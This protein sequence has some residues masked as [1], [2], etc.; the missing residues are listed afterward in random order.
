MRRGCLPLPHG[1]GKGEARKEVAHCPGISLS[2]V[3]NCPTNGGRLNE[4]GI[5]VDENAK[6]QEFIAMRAR[7]LPLSKVM[8]QLNLSLRTATDWDRRL[9]DAIGEARGHVLTSEGATILASGAG[10]G[11]GPGRGAW[12][13]LLRVL[14]ILYFMILSPVIGTGLLGLLAH[15]RGLVYWLLI[16]LVLIP[17]GAAGIAVVRWSHGAGHTTPSK[18]GAWRLRGLHFIVLA[19]AGVLANSF[20]QHKPD[21]WVTCWMVGLVTV[22]ITCLIVLIRT[23]T[24]LW[25][26]Y[27]TIGVCLAVVWCA[28]YVPSI[29]RSI[30][31]RPDTERAEAFAEV[32]AN[33][34]REGLGEIRE[35]FGREQSRPVELAEPSGKVLVLFAVEG[36]RDTYRLCLSECERFL[37]AAFLAPSPADLGIIVIHKQPREMSGS[38]FG[39]PS[40]G[41]TRDLAVPV[42]VY[43]WPDKASVRRS[44]L[45]LICNDYDYWREVAVARSLAR[46][47]EGLLSPERQQSQPAKAPG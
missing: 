18:R 27:L 9:S 37:P 22:N 30:A 32:I 24:F 31:L 46:G 11:K 38:V 28:V 25:H 43:T 33:A 8:E 3:E 36:A 41:P 14:S 26:R 2:Y 17:L 23:Q 6:Q 15:P 44:D 35:P 40:P 13:R 4:K 10:A 16:C 42:L 29:R 39:L 34:E 47:I 19:S 12:R 20:L 45:Q 21:S 7:G 5:P 1:S